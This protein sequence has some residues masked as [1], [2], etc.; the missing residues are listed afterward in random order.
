MVNNEALFVE[1]QSIWCVIV[2]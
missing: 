2:Y 1:V